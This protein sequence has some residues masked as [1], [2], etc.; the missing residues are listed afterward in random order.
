[1]TGVATV[2]VVVLGV[3]M[4]ASLYASVRQENVAALVNTVGSIAVTL[5]P[6]SVLVLPGWPSPDVGLLWELAFWIAVAG[7]LHSLGM[8]SLYESTSWW[9]HL[10]HV[11][12][13]TLLAALLYAAYLVAL[14]QPVDWPLVAVATLGST[15][16][17]G[18]VWELVE[19][20]ARDVGRRYDVEPMLVYYGWLD[21]AFDLVFDVAGAVLVVW[22][23]L[24]PFVPLLEPFPRATR[25]L[26]TVT[27]V[28][29]VV[30]GAL[31]A[32]YVVVNDASPTE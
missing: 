25:T 10:T 26:L 29:A 31:M 16:A 12:S 7:V 21:S 23:D 32:A 27:G 22:L 19:L 4:L 3:A 13:A 18:V 6:F 9:D 5:A 17:L 15:F 20:V 2:G 28:V 30:G 8:L 1:M 11:V 14:E 24:R